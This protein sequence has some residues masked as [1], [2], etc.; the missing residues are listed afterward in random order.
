[1]VVDVP[2]LVSNLTGCRAEDWAGDQDRDLAARVVENLVHLVAT[3]S[4]GAKKGSTAPYSWAELVLAEAG[5][6]QPRTLAN[7][8]RDPVRPPSSPEALEK[9]E[10][11]GGAASKALNTELAGLDAMFGAGEARLQS[12]RGPAALDGVAQ[13]PLPDLAARLGAMIRAASTEGAA[14]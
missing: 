3:V 12:A 7:A 2:L 14:G 6:R 4:P 10:T 9:G 11:L 13:A 5:E 1:M 8:F